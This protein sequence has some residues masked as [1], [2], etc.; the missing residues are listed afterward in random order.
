MENWKVIKFKEFIQLQRG[1]DLF[2]SEYIDGPYPVI[3]ATEI[4]GYHKYHKVKG[5]SLVVGRV[6][7]I[8]NV[9]YVE[10]DYW[11]HQDCLWL[12]D[13]KGNDL[14]FIYY[15]LKVLPLSHMN[16]GGAVPALNRNHLDGIDVNIPDLPTQQR[17]A[18]I[19]SAYDELIE[20]NNQRIQLLEDTARQLYKEWFVRLRFPGHEQTNFVKG[21]PDS[22]SEISFR[23]FIKLNRGFDLP[24]EQITEGEYP[25]VAST[26]IKAYHN[27][28]KIEA[29]C[30]A[31][32]RSGSLGTVQY[33]NQR[34]WP[35]NTSLYVKDFKGNSPR[36][37]YYLL[38][39]LNL[40]SF[41]AG[42]GVPS[43]NQNHL[44]SLK[45]AVPPKKLQKRFDDFIMP[46]FDQIETLQSQN[47][48]L[49]HIRDRLLPRLISGKLSVGA[50]QAGRE[51]V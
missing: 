5:P 48:Q 25:V 14:K 35:L 39:S 50:V 40:E 10:G 32:G 12:K 4:A 8:G 38:Q 37:V 45:F 44:H 1:F 6:G 30:V 15:Y 20:V 7:T 9:Q 29:P 26:S 46:I 34:S 11:P 2:K 16:A 36:Y 19:L 23:D 42:A 13:R 47:K 24:D 51:N 27:Q 17:I 18:G 43:L 22:W 3:G 33:I 49:R 31:T 28:Y 41:N 21:V